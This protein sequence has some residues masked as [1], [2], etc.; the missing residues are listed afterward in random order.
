[1][2]IAG[3]MAIFLLVYSFTSLFLGNTPERAFKL[4]KRWIR[5]VTLPL[6]NIKC[7]V[8]GKPPITPALYVCN[9]RSF[10]D[11]LINCAYLDAYVIAKAEIANYPII[12][13]GAEATGVLWVKRDSIQSRSATREKLVETLLDGYNILVY[14]EGTVGVTPETLKFSKGTFAE[15]VK[16]NIPVVPIALEYRD[17]KDLW[18]DTSFLQ[19][20]FN[21]FA[22]WRTEIKMSF[23]PPMTAEDGPQLSLDAHAWI[24]AELK[25]MQKDWSR[26]HWEKFV[27]KVDQ[28]KHLPKT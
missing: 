6:L 15:A 20:Y 24:N 22:A 9:H 14:P 7:E 13:K 27:D 23:G 25:E 1:M 16:N 28:S 19:H 21:Q 11:P 18:Q 26:V 2:L 3:T 5:W 8:K 17:T 10:I 4:R 12:N